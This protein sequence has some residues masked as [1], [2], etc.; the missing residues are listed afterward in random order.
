MTVNEKIVENVIRREGERFVVEL[1]TCSK[2]GI[3]RETLADW[4]GAIATVEDVRRLTREEATT[5]Y[6]AW[7]DKHRISEIGDAVLRDLVF[8]AAV[9]HGPARGVRWLQRA[10]NVE[11]DGIIGEETL[12]A[13]AAA[14][15][16]KVYVG[17]LKR[18]IMFYG[19]IVSADPRQA[20][21]IEGWLNRAA[22]FIR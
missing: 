7:I 21:Y 3:T 18:R 9:N 1:S 13:L 16:R 12:G 14:D 11:D 17:V 6:L 2:Y 22:E 15:A 10:L 19:R 5:F 8:D 4:R 20:I